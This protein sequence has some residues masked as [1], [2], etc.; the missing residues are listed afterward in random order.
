MKMVL[1]QIS[2][3]LPYITYFVMFFAECLYFYF[4]ESLIV[5]LVIDRVKS[6]NAD[7]AVNFSGKSL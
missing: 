3:L 1:T 2:Y 7:V 5:G 6:R 4:I